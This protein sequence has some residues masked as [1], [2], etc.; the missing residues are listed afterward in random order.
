MVNTCVCGRLL[1]PPQQNTADY[2]AS[3]SIHPLPSLLS[4]LPL[5]LLPLFPLLL[6]LPLVLPTATVYLLPSACLCI[7]SVTRIVLS[8]P[9]NRAPSPFHCL[10]QPYP[11]PQFTYEE[12]E[13][14]GGEIICSQVPQLVI[15]Q[16][17]D[18][19]S[20]CLMPNKAHA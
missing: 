12:T 17:W 16:K 10:P 9:Y 13:A 8:N 5:S 6:I 19:N 1:G 15:G 3:P 11:P 18:S 14:L 2:V 7:K 4:P 20:G